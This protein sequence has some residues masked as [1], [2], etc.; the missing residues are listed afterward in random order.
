[1]DITPTGVVEQAATNAAAKPTGGLLAFGLGVFLSFRFPGER[2]VLD[3]FLVT[4]RVLGLIGGWLRH[5]VLLSSS[6][7]ASSVLAQPTVASP[8]MSARSAEQQPFH[9]YRTTQPNECGVS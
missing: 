5:D 1:M 7:L 8:S 9:V 3:V 2:V 6:V 4:L